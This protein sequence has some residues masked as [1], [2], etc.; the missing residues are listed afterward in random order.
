MRKFTAAY[1]QLF[2]QRHRRSASFLTYI[3]SDLNWFPSLCATPSGRTQI[4][5]PHTVLCRQTRPIDV[6]RTPWLGES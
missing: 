1:E 2:A 4:A 5:T 3:G 6:S